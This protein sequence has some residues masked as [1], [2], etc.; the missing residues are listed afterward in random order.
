MHPN[1]FPDSLAH[2]SDSK[3]VYFILDGIGDLPTGPGGLTP[4][5]AAQTPH[6][7]ALCD[8][9][10]CGLLDPIQPG[11]TPGS[12]PSHLS[13]FGYDPVE[14]WVGRGILSALGLDFPIQPDDVAAR[15]NFATRDKAGN[16]TDRRA[17]RIDDETNRR[18][19]D[20]LN[21][22]G[23]S[24]HLQDVE[25]FVR[26]ENGHRALVVFRRRGLS[27]D[28]FDTDPQTLGVP[29]FPARAKSSKADRT[30]KAVAAFIDR[31]HQL[32]ADEPRA[33]TVLLRGFDTLR[34][35]PTL[36]D[37]Y[38]LR[39]YAIA[40]Y[41]MYK[42]LA[43]LVGMEVD[44]GSSDP[45]EQVQIVIRNWEDHD[46]FY[47]HLKA[48]DLFGENGDFDGKKTAIETVDAALP[49]L[50]ERMFEGEPDGSSHV[51]I[52]TG[53]HSTPVSMKAHSWHPVPAL[54]RSHRARA[55][56]QKT[57]G[58]RSCL[59]GGLGRIP[60]RHLMAIAL[61]NAG[62]LSKYGA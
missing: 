55:D 8:S 47:V 60:M 18:L 51:L 30:V 21:E 45:S 29:P 3:I 10:I 19:V 59:T 22:G 2:E 14:T 62:R 12:G 32:L 1:A 34:N 16:I 36:A 58:E 13:L 46:L 9:G 25:C 39:S 38:R 4:L 6:L 43:K 27:A 56:D 28:M 40:Y 33:N 52:V 54:L 48:T 50:V 20:I 11:V 23:E 15:M 5:E 41:P 57:F 44:A 53:D 49:P 61:A 24:V 26:S 37:R 31:A 42:G 35:L 17:G 7:D